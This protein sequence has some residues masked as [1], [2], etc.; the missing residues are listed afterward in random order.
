VSYYHPTG[1][2]GFALSL[3]EK[4][5]RIA[6]VGLGTGAVAAYLEPAEDLVFY[7]INPLSE[8]LARDWFSYL[9]DTKGSVEVRI[10][11]ARLMLE[12]EDDQSKYDVIFV[13]AFA[14]DGIPTH[15]LTREA[16]SIYEN[17]LQKGGLLIIHISNRYYDLR[18]V[19]CAAARQRGWGAAVAF[20]AMM[21]PVDPLADSSSTVVMS[22]NNQ[23]LTPLFDA[24]WANLTQDPRF[25]TTTEWTDDYVDILEPFFAMRAERAR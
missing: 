1:S 4:P 6:G 17:R 24:G 11:D 3:R 2:N 23:R 12:R 22:S 18:G 16:I 15:L 14:G 5:S 20:G 8:T 9:D 25:Q 10:G 7:E 13:D 19:L 21:K